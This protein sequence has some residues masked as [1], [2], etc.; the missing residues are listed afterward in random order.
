VIPGIAHHVTQ[1][2]NRRGDIFH[3][4]EDRH[5]YFELL[6]E[7]SLRHRLRIW[8]YN[9]MTNHTHLIAVP[10]SSSAL[11]DAL[12]DTHGA[13]ATLFNRKYGFSGHLWQARFYS[14][15]LDDEHLEHAVRYVEC[16]PVRAGMVDRAED[17]PFSSAGPHVCGVEDR[18][19][20]SGLPLVGVIQD[21]SAWLA[22]EPDEN[23]VCVIREATATGRACGSEEFVRGVEEYSGRCLRP[24]K[25]GRKP[26]PITS[27][28]ENDV[29]LPLGW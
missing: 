14:C 8:A 2:G 10:E 22:G 28:E 21:W 20:D 19:V 12:R 26:R 15:V 27:E 1:R 7:Y 16:N 25:R 18:Y 23:A 3:D 9:L 24:Q 4:A 17:Y 13:Y 29:M 5:L 6:R 11:S